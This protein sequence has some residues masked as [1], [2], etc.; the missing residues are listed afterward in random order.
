MHTFRRKCLQSRKHSSAPKFWACKAS[1]TCEHLI[2]TSFLPH[3]LIV[4]RTLGCFRCS[5]YKLENFIWDA[6][7]KGLKIIDYGV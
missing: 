7:S 3:S 5:D 4:L 1:F 6:A 2:E